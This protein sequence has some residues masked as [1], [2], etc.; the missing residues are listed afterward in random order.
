MGRC[1][2]RGGVMI[3]QAARQWLG[4][5]TFRR[6][7]QADAAGGIARVTRAL[8]CSDAPFLMSESNWGSRELSSADGCGSSAAHQAAE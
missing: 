4:L 2:I 7:G 3:G 6:C 5:V 1:P 8:V